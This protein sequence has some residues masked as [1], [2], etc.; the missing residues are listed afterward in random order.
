MIELTDRLRGIRD[1]CAD[2][3]LDLRARALKVDADPDSVVDHLDTGVF[4]MI[5]QSSTPAEYREDLPG[6]PLRLLD[7]ESCLENVVGLVEL[8]RGDAG[9]VLS[10]PSPALA[11]VLV[12]MLGNDEQ[13]KRF[14]TRLH[15]GGTWTFFAMSE[16]DRGSDATLMRTRFER[17]GHGGWL[18]HGGK[19]YIGNGARGAI[20][21]VFGRT[22]RSPLTI[23]AALV[24]LPA[25][26][27]QAR[28]LPTV[29]L[30]GAC[31]SELEFDGVPVPSEMMLGEHL[32]VTRRGLWGA[33]MTFNNMRIQVAA[34][35]VGTATAMV[36]YVAEQRPGAP[37]AE[38]MANRV[39]AARELVYEA[40]ARIDHDPQRGYLSCAAKL[41]ATR[42]AVRVGRWCAGA[43]GPS[44]LIEHPLLEK[45]TRDACAFEFMEGTT[46]IQRMHVTRGYQAGD[47]DA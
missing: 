47:A 41:G 14:Y 23:R 2:M 3:A 25:P 15:G 16:R 17:D 27:W 21:V 19:R 4:A 39:E 43:L 22:G 6:R 36:R 7:N 24:E 12:N 13:K 18:L 28:P 35:A 31:L 37:N 26:G 46:N 1:T 40:A 34:M 8:A 10:C 29:G 45:W 33:M 42:M 5:R 11:G 32:P 38:T 20:G 44:G 9:M 30:R